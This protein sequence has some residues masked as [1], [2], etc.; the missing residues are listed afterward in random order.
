VVRAT[1]LLLGIGLSIASR[2]LAVAV[3]RRIEQI[4]G[5]LP[6]A[7][8]G[9]CGYPGCSAFAKA[10]AEGK[11]SAGGCV[12]GGAKVASDI[13]ELLGV[14]GEVADPLMAVVHCKGGNAE[15]KKRGVYAGIHDCNAA[16]LAGNGDKVCQEGCLGMG[17][18]V[19]V[20]PF[21]AIHVN[22]NG[23]AVVDDEK[24]TGCGKCVAACPRKIISLIPKLHRIFLACSSH[25]RGA[26]VRKD[27][28]VGCTACTLCVKA[29][30][31]GAIVMQNNLPELD[32]KTSETFIVAANKCP[33]KCFV[34]LVKVRPVANIDTKCDGCAK[35]VPSCP[36]KAITGEQGQR[37]VIEKSTCI[38]C[39][40][41]IE[42]C[43]VRAIAMW[44]G[45][46]YSTGEGKTRRTA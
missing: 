7:N 16:V 26:K 29:T 5:L 32:Y 3:D 39:G 33:S 23:V 1:G 13:S 20:C 46:G 8:C 25:G 43:P 30:P 45:L 27:C 34:D 22:D 44:G 4:L 35:C 21:D 17:S 6:G 11:A 12:P 42:V 15:A 38:G 10:V 14:D 28:S 24:C 2:K 37:H 41:C 19:V 9:A 40:L 36:V 18:C 31:S